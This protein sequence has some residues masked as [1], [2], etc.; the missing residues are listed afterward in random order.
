MSHDNGLLPL[1][2]MLDSCDPLQS[3]KQ[4]SVTS[5]CLLLYKGLWGDMPPERVDTIQNEFSITPGQ[6]REHYALF[7]LLLTTVNWLAYL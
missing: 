6:T 4:T 1:F 3:Q 2:L 7:V 5:G